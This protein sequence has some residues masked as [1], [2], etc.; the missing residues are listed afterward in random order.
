MKTLVPSPQSP[1]P[2]Y[3]I[4]LEAAG[5][6]CVVVGGGEVALRKIRGLRA[7]G[8]RVKV[9]APEICAG[10]EELLQ[11]GEISWTRE[12]FSEDLLGDELILIAATD[13]ATVN[14]QACESAKAR[15]IL[16]NVVDAAGG[17]FNVPSTIR[18][19]DLL[20][21]ISTGGNSPA[22][23]KFLRQMLEAELGND[24]A[25]GLKIISQR[26][27]EVKRL[28]PN[29][30]VRQKFWQQIF[31]PQT[32]QLLKSGQLNELEAL[33]DNALKNFGA[34]SHDGTD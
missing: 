21:T 8:A 30:K 27:R 13:S 20:L 12:K 24:F 2:T 25:A 32:W 29:P 19:G 16:V 11:R 22:F 4:N 18:R 23:S 33:I 34:Q 5:K 31:T 14:R 7:A 26:R 15:K 10:V 9:I 28:L 1:V 17:N 6:P 3:P